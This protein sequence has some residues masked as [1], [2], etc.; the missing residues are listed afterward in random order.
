MVA[1][2]PAVRDEPEAATANCRTAGGAGGTTRIRW[3]AQLHNLRGRG[4]QKTPQGMA[5][6]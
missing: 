5:L 2:E 1:A 6:T 4:K 3:A